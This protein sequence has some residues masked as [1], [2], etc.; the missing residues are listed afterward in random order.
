MEFTIRPVEL[1][2]ARGLNALRRMPGV[3]ETITSTPG[4]R[5]EFSEK[6][7][8]AIADSDCHF[9]AVA[10]GEGGEEL[11]IGSA[12]LAVFSGRMRHCAGFGI[13]V[14]RDWQGRD[15][16]SAL[17]EACLDM[18]DNWWKLARVEL[19]VFADNARAIRLYEK[20][21]FEKEGVRRMACIRGG[22]YEDELYMAR[23]RP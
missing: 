18:A 8:A 7:V 1:K 15:V 20:Y 3:R 23:L 17:M 13:M 19:T 14:H 6:F 4:E 5:V 2:D 22:Q 10:A 12:G 9:V 21:G 11:V 16:G